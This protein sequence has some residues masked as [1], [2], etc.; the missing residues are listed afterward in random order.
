MAA[1][2][3]MFVVPFPKRETPHQPHTNPG[4][5][6]DVKGYDVDVKSYDVDV[7]KGYICYTNWQE[8]TA[9]ATVFRHNRIATR[10]TTIPTYRALSS[11]HR[12]IRGDALGPNS[13]L[14]KK[15]KGRR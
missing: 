4:Y 6:A 1:V 3:R 11:V 14:L 13:E 15:N 5:D 10:N 2:C 12:T 7:Y 9:T 8:T